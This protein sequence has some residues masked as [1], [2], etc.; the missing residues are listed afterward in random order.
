MLLSE[1]E[2]IIVG[3][4]F[5]LCVGLVKSHR[6]VALMVGSIGSG[7]KLSRS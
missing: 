5:S 4:A 3:S 2:L 7:V 1:E 6:A